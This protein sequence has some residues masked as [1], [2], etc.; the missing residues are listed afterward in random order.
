M[1]AH[2][3]HD[4]TPVRDR[5]VSGERQRFCKRHH[6]WWPLRLFV[7]AKQGRLGFLGYCRGCRQGARCYVPPTPESRER[8]RLTKRARYIRLV[9][10]GMLPSQARRVA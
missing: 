7:K 5:I 6:G 9:S 2:S 4:N 1:P 3:H 8:K 10:A